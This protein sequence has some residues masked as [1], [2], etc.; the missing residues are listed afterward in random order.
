MDRHPLLP[1]PTPYTALGLTGAADLLHHVN[2]EMVEKSSPRASLSPDGVCGLSSVCRG[3]PWVI[4]VFPALCPQPLLVSGSSV[5]LLTAFLMLSF[6]CALN[7][8]DMFLSAFWKICFFVHS[9][10]QVFMAFTLPGFV[11]L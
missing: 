10:L 1:F 8:T 6:H 9:V 5:S 2:S 3:S 4:S 7:P 11:C